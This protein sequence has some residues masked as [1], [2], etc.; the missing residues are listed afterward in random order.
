[1]ILCWATF[2]AIL[3]WMQPMGGRLDTPALK[4]PVKT[5]QNIWRLKG[6]LMIKSESVRNSGPWGEYSRA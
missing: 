2:I 4:A 3:G 5:S 6:D 1:M